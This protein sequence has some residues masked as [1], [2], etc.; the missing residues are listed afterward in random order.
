[1]GDTD[2]WAML[3]WATGRGEL[4]GRPVLTHWRWEGV[5]RPNQPE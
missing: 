3:L 2:P 4:S 5:P 1:M